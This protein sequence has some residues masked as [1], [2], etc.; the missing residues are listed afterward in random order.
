MLTDKKPEVIAAFAKGC[1]WREVAEATGISMMT[2][3]RWAQKDPEFAKAIKDV[4]EDADAE[5]EAVTFRNACDPD[6]ANNT[7]RMFWLKSRK[8]Y[9]DRLDIT[10]EDKPFGYV[11]RIRNPRDQ[12]LATHSNGNG[13]TT[14][15]GLAP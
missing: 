5:V 8:G 13:H 7:L 1:S 15:N 4:G 11:D 14:G 10:S 3:W 6:P 12:H 9:R 2:I